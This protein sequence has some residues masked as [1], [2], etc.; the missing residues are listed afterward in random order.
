MS[1]PA[2]HAGDASAAP[3]A[4]PPRAFGT[5]TPAVGSLA[6]AGE[7]FAA[8]IL[9]LLVGSACLVWIAPDLAAG[10]YP[11]PRVAAVTHLFTLGWLTT[12]IF[13]A[14]YQL[15]P[16]A[17]GAAPRWPRLGHASFWS[18]VPGVA[19]F[20]GGIATGKTALHH[21]GIGLLTVGIVLLVTNV[22]ASLARS[23]A[24]D[25]TWAGITIALAFLA[26]TLV[27]GVVLLHNIHTGFLGEDRLRVLAVHLHVAL[28]GWALVMIVGV[29]H[30]LLPMF[31][32]AHN[33]DTRWTKR[34]LAL[35]T[36]GVPVLGTGI[37][38]ASGPLAWTGGAL[39]V[40]GVGCF[41]TQAAMFFRARVRR[42]LDVG[43]RFVMLAVGFLLLATALG[44]TL[45]ALGVAHTRLATAYVLVGLLGGIVLYV[46]GHFYKIVPLLA[47][48]VRYR[49]RLGRGAVPTVAATF[50]ARVAYAQLAAMTL[51]VA[52]MGGGTLAGHVHCVR[53]GAVVWSAGVLLFTVQIARVAFG[54]PAGE[55]K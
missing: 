16:V 53:A 45:L 49:D 37:A 13:G 52:A 28:V 40:A 12:T 17:L 54:R 48:T 31:L 50:S 30:R 55:S 27:L 14:L 35:L 46:V 32:L 25:V 42:K 3:P 1:A 29:S 5:P 36:V 18:F 21:A 10:L 26:S 20:A 39:L 23:R 41:V 24:R 11:Q 44:V 43:M 15:L 47:W 8:A 51:G 9:Y 22:V 4:A 38:T 6:L 33:A 2:L 19:L 7:H 34:A